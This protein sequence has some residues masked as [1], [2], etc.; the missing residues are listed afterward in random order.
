MEAIPSRVRPYDQHG[1]QPITID[2]A[3]LS[4]EQ[5][6]LWDRTFPKLKAW[7]VGTTCRATRLELLEF[8]HICLLD[9]VPP[10][11]P[12]WLQAVLDEYAR[13]VR[14]YMTNV[15]TA[16]KGGAWF[17]SSVHSTI[18]TAE[19]GGRRVAATA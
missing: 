13:M 12:P 17:P 5:R 9:D 10:K 3:W 7:T 8:G 6:K 2:L 15:R 11:W 18:R 1:G 4:H 19:N 16:K 14:Q